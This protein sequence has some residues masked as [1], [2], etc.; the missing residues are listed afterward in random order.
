MQTNGTVIVSTGGLGDLPPT[1]TQGPTVRCWPLFLAAAGSH[2]LAGACGPADFGVSPFA[3]ALRGPHSALKARP[4]SYAFGLWGRSC[5][6]VGGM[7]GGSL[8]FRIFR[9]SF[10]SVMLLRDDVPGGCHDH[11]VTH[12]PAADGRGGRARP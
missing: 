9:F 7:E 4:L 10:V 8:P 1:N 11:P 3:T 12:P 6:Q 5:G 2:V